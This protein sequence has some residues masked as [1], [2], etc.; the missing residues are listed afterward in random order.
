MSTHWPSASNFQPWYTQRSPHS[1]LRPRKSEAWRCGQ[2]SSRSPMRPRLSRKA[3]SSSPSSFT[4]TGGQ[5]GSG[6]SHPSSAGSQY[7]RMVA[8][9][10]VPGPTRVTRSLSSRA[11][12]AVSLPG[13]LGLASFGLPERWPWNGDRGAAVPHLPQHP[14]PLPLQPVERLEGGGRLGDAAGQLRMLR[15][16]NPLAAALDRL[17]HE[18]VGHRLVVGERPPV[19]HHTKGTHAMGTPASD[20]RAFSVALIQL[21]PS[22]RTAEAG[23]TRQR[24]GSSTFGGSTPWS[25]S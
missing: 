12:M 8:P 20:W 10:G 9:I 2:R 11:S 13:A 14:E 21:A 25:R 17:E 5:S 15:A 1:S 24:F 22:A 16:A 4:R 23:R 6:S 18:Q 3:T 19:V 7:R